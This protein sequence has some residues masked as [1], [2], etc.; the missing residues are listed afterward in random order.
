VG[1]SWAPKCS[2]GKGGCTALRGAGSSSSSPSRQYATSLYIFLTHADAL[3]ETTDFNPWSGNHPEDSLTEQ[4]VKSGFQ[5]KPMV[6]NELN[7]AKVSLWSHITKKGC[8][9]SLSQLFVSVLEKRQTHLRL[10]APSTFK[11]PPR[12]TLTNT[13][14]EAWLQDLANPAFALR[15][16]NRTIPY[17]I[18][19]KVLLEQCVNKDIPIPRAVWLAKCIGANE[20]RT[21]KRKGV[22]GTPGISG[23]LKWLREW[24]VHVEQFVESTITAFGEESWKDKMQYVMRLV[25]HLF[26]E[27]L[28][29]H[30]HYLDWMLSA[31]ET[32]TVE[33][34]PVWLVHIQLYWKFIVTSRKRGKRLA[35]CLF[36][37]LESA[38]TDKDADLLGS[39]LHRMQLLVATLA[40]SHRGC[41]ILPKVWTQ[42]EHHLRS[43]ITKPEFAPAQ[44]AIEAVIDRNERLAPTSHHSVQILASSPRRKVFEVLDDVGFDVSVN[45]LTTRCLDVFDTTQDFLPTILHW[46]SSVHREGPHRV[47]IA[48]RI[49][50]RCKALNADVEAAVLAFMTELPDL[51]D[52]D[53]TKISKI[54]AELVRSKQFAV[55]R[56][57]QSMI[58]M[59]R[60]DSAD[61]SSLVCLK[62]NLQ[63]AGCFTYIYS[64]YATTPK[65]PFRY[66]N[67][68]PASTRVRSTTNR[69]ER[70]WITSR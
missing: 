48:A 66:P 50:R 33:R 63:L 35:E 15:R 58:S 42:Y 37:H 30:E 67:A 4:T 34:L 45:E 19:G 25:F 23:E 61:Q 55:G 44:T 40:V 68:R 5:N 18:N 14:R 51:P 21:L 54:V 49:L 57:L 70:C 17:G 2:K 8:L 52:I 28:L 20:L 43:L 11:P 53:E 46:A 56:L 59:G 10:T 47:Y 36:K 13:K 32:S 69:L 3:A 29:E 65:P 60:V 7:T 16:L 12:V 27:H 24:T 6:T 38:S 22:T 39:V 1:T 62:Y 41:M 9:Q 64:D 31:F 26:I